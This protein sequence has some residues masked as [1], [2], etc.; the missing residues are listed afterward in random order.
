MRVPSMITGRTLDAMKP[1]IPPS[2]DG[3]TSDGISGSTHG[4]SRSVSRRKS[5]SHGRERSL[6]G[7]IATRKSSAAAGMSAASSGRTSLIGDRDSF[8]GTGMRGGE[9]YP[10]GTREAT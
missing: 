2:S 7:P 3:A 4:L 1:A 8:V 10:P 9:A 6:S 5:A